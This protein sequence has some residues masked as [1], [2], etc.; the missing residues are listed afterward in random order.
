MLS[1]LTSSL[2]VIAA[3]AAVV[4][5]SPG[6]GHPGKGHHDKRLNVQVGARPEWLVH[7]MDEGALKEKSTTK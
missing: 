2:L 5:K 6:Y 3:S 4:P 7:N 1:L